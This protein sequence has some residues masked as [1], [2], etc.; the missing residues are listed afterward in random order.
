MDEDR[1]SG[2]YSAQFA[3]LWRF[4]RRR[5]ETGDDAD[6]LVAETFA[7]AWRRRFDIPPGDDARLWLFGVARNV[8]ANHHRDTR[9]RGRLHLRLVTTTAEPPSREDGPDG[10]L[11]RALAALPEDDRELLLLRAWDRL[12]ATEIATVLGTT[13]AT[14]SSRLHKAR[15]RLDRELERLRPREER[16]A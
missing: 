3:D 8:L 9:R 1:F 15:R 10:D 6:D 11:W 5:T 2:F 16:H 7:V 14:V 12:G 13:A 4:V